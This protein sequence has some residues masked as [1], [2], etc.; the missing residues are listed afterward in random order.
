LETAR[1]I[2]LRQAYAQ[3]NVRFLEIYRT[4]GWILKLY[5]I[6]WQG[7]APHIE[8]VEQ[9]KRATARVLP[10]PA[11]TEN[12]YGVGFVIIHDGQDA[13]WL[14]VDWWELESI[15]HHQLLTMPLDGGAPFEPA[16]PGMT[17][18]VWELP[19]ILF[20]RD[21]WVNTVL[22]NPD[23]PDLTAYL[24]CQLNAKI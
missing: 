16:P 15:L 9:A 20:E 6:A 4:E 19:V 7:S 2:R 1:P 8:V 11:E 18:C 3:R 17:A 14:L 23:R 10:S 21:A 5:G 24:S 12:R 22:R 13:R